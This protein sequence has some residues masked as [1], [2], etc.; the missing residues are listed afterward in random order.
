M[1]KKK[2]CKK[3]LKEFKTD[4]KLLLFYRVL[5]LVL[6]ILKIKNSILL[7][8]SKNMNEKI[9]IINDSK[10]NSTINKINSFSNSFVISTL[11]LKN[12]VNY[13]NI[14][15][16][17]KKIIIHSLKVLIHNLINYNVLQNNLDL[18]FY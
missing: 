14:I 4:N 17:I 5:C 2:H 1:L 8:T 9:N 18:L 11:L 13:L 3:K 6:E 7:F 10:R 12:L 15:F 16:K